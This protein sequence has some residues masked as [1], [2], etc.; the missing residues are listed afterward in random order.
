MGLGY[1]TGSSHRTNRVVVLENSIA[2]IVF[3]FLLVP[4]VLA[5][6]MEGSVLYV[7]N[8]SVVCII[9]VIIVPGRIIQHMGRIGSM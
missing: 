5:T 3:V 6:G 7:G 8:N 2:N 4:A 9:F 1:D